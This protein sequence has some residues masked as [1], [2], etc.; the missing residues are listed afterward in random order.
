VL[1]QDGEIIGIP[2]CGLSNT[3]ERQETLLMAGSGQLVA[4]FIGPYDTT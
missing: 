1:N 4:T 3:W 2:A